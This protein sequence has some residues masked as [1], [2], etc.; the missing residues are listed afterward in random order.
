MDKHEFLS[1]LRGALVGRLPQQK[2]EEHIRYYEDYIDIRL[3]S[4]DPPEELY[5]R[6]GDPRLLA[7][8]LVTA[9]SAPGRYSLTGFFRT[10]LDKLID[11]WN[12]L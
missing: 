11:F 1:I 5:E 3:R 12:R 9:D 6:L 8:T 10:L 7:K 2:V 4:G